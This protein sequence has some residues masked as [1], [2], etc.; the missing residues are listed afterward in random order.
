MFILYQ[1]LY[2][3]NLSRGKLAR[4][5]IEFEFCLKMNLLS[6]DKIFI[7]MESEL[8]LPSND[9]LIVHKK[10]QT[11]FNDL[12]KATQYSGLE[13]LNVIAN[14]DIF[15]NRHELS[16]MSASLN[17]NVYALSRWDVSN[18]DEDTA[19]LFCR[20]DSQDSWAKKGP[21]FVDDANFTMG[22][23]GC[24]NRVANIL[25]KRYD[26]TN[27][28]KSIKSFH[29]HQEDLNRRDWLKKPRVKGPYTF[30]NPEEL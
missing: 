17:D 14:S 12:F 18:F 30:L 10:K 24:D 6:F 20:S 22:L 2:T 26:V 13:D 8:E 25:S 21:F 1:N 11:T 23:G 9:K 4:R 28:S 16:K 3:G 27:P 7:F 15:F 19:V 29:V 5:L